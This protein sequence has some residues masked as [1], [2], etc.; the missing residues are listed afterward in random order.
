MNKPAWLSKAVSFLA[1]N[2]LALGK[3]EAWASG[4][5]I[6]YQ[7]GS[8]TMTAQ[9]RRQV[10]AAQAELAV[11][12]ELFVPRLDWSRPKKSERVH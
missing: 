9:Y 1:A 8:D 4:Y 11:V 2:E 12:K 10:D 5:R 3:E 6:G 7:H